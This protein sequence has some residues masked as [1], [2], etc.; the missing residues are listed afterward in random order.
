M[1]V[2]RQ[3]VVCATAEVAEL[4]EV[5]VASWAPSGL[6]GA[7]CVAQCVAAVVPLVV[8]VVARTA[9]A[10]WAQLRLS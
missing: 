1:P 6:R 2:V 9:P 4:A 3:H 10:T 5:A 7:Q 8:V